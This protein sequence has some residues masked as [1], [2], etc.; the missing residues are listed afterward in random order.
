MAIQLKT[1]AL[2]DFGPPGLQPQ[3]PA[4]VYDSRAKTAY[5]RAGCDWLVIYADREHF[6]NIVFL[7][8]FEPRFEEAFLLL[9]PAGRHIL[10]TGNE[11]ESY[12]AVAGLPGLTV[13]VSQPLSLMGQDRTKYPRLEDRLRDAGIKAGDRVGLVGW[14]YFLAEEDSE[15]TTAFFVPAAYVRM[16]HRVVGRDGT[17]SDATAILMHPETGLRAVIDADQIAAFEWAATRC[18]LA[19]WR[20]VCGVR[21]GDTEFAAVARMAYEGDPLNVH[22]MF[23][24]A[25]PGTPVI[26]LRSPT[27]RR[28]DRGD[29]V[30][31]AIGLWG[32]LSSRAGL[33][34][35][36]NDDFLQHA[37][38]YFAGLTAWYEA[39]D[40]GVAGGTLHAAVT[41]ALAAGGLRP[42]LNPGHLTGHEE[43][44]HSPV[45]PGSPDRLRSGMPF[46]VDVIPVPLPDG[47]T[48]NCE[49]P[50]TF[51][52]E[53]LRVD[54]KARHPDCFAR[55]EARRA[56]MRNELGVAVRE[57]IL[58]LSSTPLYLP[59]FWLEPSRVLV[60]G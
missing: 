42:A 29:G 60:R 9:G 45:R 40:I 14:K 1:I 54:I 7:T 17:V 52:D 15:A 19:V 11:S 26:G 36:G 39:A 30:T 32:A 27:G 56:F 55:I 44:M 48:L 22:T 8:G 3:I 57:S 12:A 37:K 41:E 28:L 47:W 35:T 6:G 20:I 2:P 5:D 21:A 31:T 18:S 33:L 24:S 34:D 58:P 10:L 38:A 46:Q 59:P 25:S 16:L 13:L 50:V 4:R 23:A 43:W 49:D 53:T 51:A